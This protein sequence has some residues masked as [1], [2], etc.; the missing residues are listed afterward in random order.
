MASLQTLNVGHNVVSIKPEPSWTTW[1]DP[2]MNNADNDE[3]TVRLAGV[4]GGS[5][6]GTIAI[7]DKPVACQRGYGR[8]G[9]TNNVLC[10]FANGSITSAGSNTS[11]NFLKYSLPAG[12]T[13]PPWP[14]PTAASSP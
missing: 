10:V 14:S 4:R 7:D 6:I 3:N 5:P 1:I 11:H 12:K 9:W 13:P 2:S 8:G